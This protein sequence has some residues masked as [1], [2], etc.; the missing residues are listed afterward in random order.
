M[1]NPEPKSESIG[2]SH[3]VLAWLVH[4]YTASGI[5]W[6]VLTLHAIIEKRLGDV[7]FWMLTAVVVDATD[8][9]LARKFR[10]KEVLPSVDGTLLDNIVDYLNWSFI[11]AV[12]LWLSGWLVGPSWLWCSLLLVCSA[13][14][15]VHSDAKVVDEGFFRGFPSYWNIGAFFVDLTYLELGPSQS[16]VGGVIVTS[17]VVILSLLSVVPVYFVYPTRAIRWRPFFVG[18]SALWTVHCA[19]MIGFYPHVPSWLY[20][21]SLVYPTA[22]LLT[23]FAWTPGVHRR[24]RERM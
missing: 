22:Y 19:V 12:F 1:E 24:V 16:G 13:F 6:G 8:G 21:S 4:L 18:G 9:F 15:F 11:P 20:W 17:A 2:T 3:K 7:Y 14:A 23:S 10:V 5:L